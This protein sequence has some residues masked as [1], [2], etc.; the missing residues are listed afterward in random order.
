M[1]AGDEFY[2]D[3]CTSGLDRSE[4]CTRA[5]H[6]DG[7]SGLAGGDHELRQVVIEAN[8]GFLVVAE[9]AE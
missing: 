6:I 5:G 7:C 4:P 9:V 3:D 8:E 1:M 2:D